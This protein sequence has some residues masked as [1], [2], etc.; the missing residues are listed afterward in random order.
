M[1]PR[2]LTFGSVA[3]DYERYRPGYPGRLVDDV[4]SYAARPVRRAL[5]IGA[6]T[7]KATRVFARRDIAV[8][9]TDP[10]AAMLREL[11][12]HVPSTVTVMQAAFEDL[13]LE[14]SYDL[15]FAAASMHWTAAVGRWERVAAL[16]D[17]AGTF[18]CF[19]GQLS[20]ADPAVE[21]AVQT[22]RAPLLDSDAFP[23]PDGTPAGS[24]TLWPATELAQST[25]FT[26]VRQSP[27]DRGA[28]VSA[29]DYVGH[30]ATVSAYLELPRAVRDDVLARVLRVLPDRV[31]VVSDIVVHL[32][33]R[34]G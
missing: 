7:G 11:G 9:A 13:T 23:S 10:D 14:R 20:L 5:E 19:G 3:A 32:A 33:R 30:L 21:A 17:T 22:A 31:E 4:L 29:H 6:G 12:K 24:Q 18:A 2:A 16:L 15:V 28:I 27:V 26:D 1:G 25:L 34:A 8:T